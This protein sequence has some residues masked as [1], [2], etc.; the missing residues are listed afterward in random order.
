MIIIKFEKF[1]NFIK[2]Q[3]INYPNIHFKTVR[4]F[5]DNLIKNLSELEKER[6]SLHIQT[7]KSFTDKQI[8]IDNFLLK[9]NINEMEKELE[10]IKNGKKE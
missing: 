9:N 10:V 4:L 8:T 3:L 7:I 6:Y 5:I 1:F 2:Y